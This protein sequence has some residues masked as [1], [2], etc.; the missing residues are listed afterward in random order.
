MELLLVAF[1]ELLQHGLGKGFPIPIYPCFGVFAEFA[2]FLLK[3]GT[4]GFQLGVERSRLLLRHI[5]R[6]MNI[7][8]RLYRFAYHLRGLFHFIR[9]FGKV[10]HTV[11]FGVDN[12]S[13][14]VIK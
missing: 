8:N 3:H 12:P 10:L 14:I 1:F 9:R 2:V 6:C 5:L 4:G 11:G 13:G 7:V